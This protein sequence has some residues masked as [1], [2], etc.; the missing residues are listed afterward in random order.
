MCIAE[1][2]PY[3]NIEDLIKLYQINRYMKTLMT[4]GSERCLRF[5]VMFSKQEGKAF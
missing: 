4:P 3:L 5:D 2:L 1:L